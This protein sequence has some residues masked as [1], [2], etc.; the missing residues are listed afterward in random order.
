MFKALA[1]VGLLMVLVGAGLGFGP[2]NVGSVSCGSSLNRA[3]DLRP[4]PAATECDS[5]RHD[6]EGVAIVLLVVGAAAALG[7]GMGLVS[8]REE[9]SAKEGFSPTD[10]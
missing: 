8:E 7:G 9:D 1:V 3:D 10:S 4:G 5:R 2:I 6:R